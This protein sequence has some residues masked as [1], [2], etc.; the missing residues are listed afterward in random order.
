MAV[1]FKFPVRR[2]GGKAMTSSWGV[3]CNGTARTTIALI[4]LFVLTAGVSIP[5][6]PQENPDLNTYFRTHIGLSEIQI[7]AV[8]SGKG[9]AKALPSRPDG[10]VFVFGAIHIDA[11]AEAYFKFCHDFARLRQVPSYI[12]I[13][14]FSSPPKIS[15]LKDLTLDNDEIKSL[16]TCKPGDC[17]FQLPA[18]AIDKVQQA[19]DWFDPD[20]VQHINQMLQETALKRLSDYQREGNRTLGMYDDKP[21]SVDVAAQFKYLLSYF[22]VLPER[23]PDFYN[24]LL[25][26]PREMPAN[27][28]DVFYWAKVK[29][30]LKPTLRI[31]HVV[32]MRGSAGSDLAYVIAEKQ[33]Y[34]SHYFRTALDLTYAISDA[35]DPNR[36]SFYLIKVMGSEQAGLKGLKGSIV[37]QVASDRSAVAL[38]KS[39]AAIKAELEQ[40][41]NL[42]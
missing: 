30:G 26:Y 21:L 27:V 18:T 40:N 35:S 9:F 23:L 39:L 15:D 33:L 24:Y 41:L 14:E 13:G 16:R 5:C 11:R 19:T 1:A 31:V 6:L 36:P 4:E 7:Q 42:R 37:R 38:Q 28:E 17:P 22:R 3:L 12:G 2:V 32:T 8:R 29:F 20:V 25:S 10:E 34:A